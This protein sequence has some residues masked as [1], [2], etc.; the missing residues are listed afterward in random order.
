MDLFQILFQILGLLLELQVV[1]RDGMLQG[2]VSVLHLFQLKLKLDHLVDSVVEVLLQLV[3]D[4]IK[5]LL[6][7]I[8]LLFNNPL[9]DLVDVWLLLLKFVVQGGLQLLDLCLLSSCCLLELLQ[10]IDKLIVIVENV[11]DVTWVDECAEAAL[12]NKVCGDLLFVREHLNELPLL[13]LGL[14]W[15]DRPLHDLVDLRLAV[16]LPVLVSLPLSDQ[17][18]QLVYDRVLLLQLEVQLPNFFL[19]VVHER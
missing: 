19:D 2:L 11:L 5:L 14:L 7:V 4:H 3:T 15:L 1:S 9:S 16:L 17:F 12:G 8:K 13:A 10:L 18:R 6:L